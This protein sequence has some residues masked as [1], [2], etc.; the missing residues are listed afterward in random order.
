[1]TNVNIEQFDNSFAKLY[2]IYPNLW[3][4]LEL[5]KYL[6]QKKIIIYSLSF[7]NASD[8]MYDND[9]KSCQY[10]GV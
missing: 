2:W 7:T 9:K 10:S 1:M 8:H 4:L 6:L 3:S 5:E